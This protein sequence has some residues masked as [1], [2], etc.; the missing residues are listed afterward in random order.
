MCNDAREGCSDGHQAPL[1][2]AVS[3]P[4]WPHP[5]LRAP[6]RR[7]ERRAAGK[8]GSDAF[9]TA[10]HAALVGAPLAVRSFQPRSLAALIADFYSSVEYENLKPN[11]QKTYRSVLNPLAVKHG[12]RLVRDAT[13]EKIEAI[14]RGI[15]S[16][17]RTATG[18]TEAA[19]RPAMANLTRSVLHLLFKFAVRKRWCSSNPV[20]GLGSYTTGTHHTWTDEEIAAYK[21]RWPIG[22]RE[23]L[24]FALLFF[25]DQRGG[26]VVR[27]KRTDVTD[28]VIR[29]SQQKVRK[30]KEK[31]VRIPLHPE[32]VRT[33][34]AGP[35]NI[36]YLLGNLNGTQM[37]RGTLTRL[38]R[39]AAS[40]A[41]LPNRCKAH[42][43]RK[44]MQRV[45][46]ESGATGKELQAV[47]G[48]ATLEQT[49]LY[50]KDAEQLLL[51]RSAFNRIGG[52]S[53]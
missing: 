47:A 35:T 38:I 20:T 1:H 18:E 16:S 27:M 48:H 9:L 24:A 26:D 5:I 41:G 4:A 40:K 44:A 43:L 3:G 32:L 12:H 13:P 30:G 10:Y 42:G 52:Q 34:R 28:G 36:T 6:P 14:I 23:R 37:T 33:L 2:Q 15:G 46:A 50:T 19:G 53:V 17:K 22:T 21:K 39:D 31:V 25:T 45:L 11:S 7:A 29:V 49:D 8:P 51:A